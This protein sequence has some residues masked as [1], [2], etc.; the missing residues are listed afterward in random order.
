MNGL[1]GNLLASL[2]NAHVSWPVGLA[3]I[4]EI[5][6]IFY[7]AYAP[8]CKQVQTVLLSYGIIAA[9]NSPVIASEVPVPPVPPPAPAAPAAAPKP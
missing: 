7:P 5:V 6:P 8:Q 2:S 9:A 1:K 4:L 3:I